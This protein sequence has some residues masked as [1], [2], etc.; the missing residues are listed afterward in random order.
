MNQV[1]AFAPALA[2]PHDNAETKYVD[3]L[4]EGWAKWSQSSGIDQ[5]PTSF[6]KLWHIHSVEE[7]GHELVI[8]DDQFL[9]IDQCVASL[10][11]RLR[12]VVYVEYLGYGTGEDKAR[13]FGL[14]YTAYRQR[15][16]AAQ[17]TLF[18]FLEPEID[19]LRAQRV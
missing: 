10:H 4:L 18:A 15:L 17:W 13:R 19:V 5:R 11:H 2:E 8:S 7:M 1:A 12:G 14:K 3:R 9:V 6:G 16:H